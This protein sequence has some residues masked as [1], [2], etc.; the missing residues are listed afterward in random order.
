MGGGVS[1]SGSLGG[2]G[3]G[4][5]RD[6]SE[7]ALNAGI[8]G[9]RGGIAGGLSGILELSWKQRKYSRQSFFSFIQK[10]Q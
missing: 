7:G 4:L 10:R 9:S 6:P 8:R 1:G 2:G 3:G 5:C